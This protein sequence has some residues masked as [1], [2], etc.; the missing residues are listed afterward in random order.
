MST[1]LV[2]VVTTTANKADAE[3]LAQA[4]LEQRFAACVQI[5][6]P[7]ESHYWWNGSLDK[8]TEWSVLMKTHS[9]LLSQLEKLILE[10]HPYDQPEIIATAAEHVSAG[11]LKW[12]KDELR[13]T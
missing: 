4:V 7:I 1:E 9:T 11:Y 12:L 8:A 5:A 10:M 6:G 2:Q 13:V 3:R